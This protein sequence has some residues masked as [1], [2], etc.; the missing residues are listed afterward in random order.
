[1]KAT[2]AVNVL[3]LM[4]PANSRPHSHHYLVVV[5]ILTLPL[6]RQ[7]QPQAHPYKVSWLYEQLTG[8]H[9]PSLRHGNL[10][11]IEPAVLSR[12]Q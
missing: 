6:P 3:L 1:M 5:G 7:E 11:I 8:P 9:H 12:E 10:V 2:T 4:H